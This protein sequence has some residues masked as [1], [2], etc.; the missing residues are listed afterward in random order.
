MRDAFR[1]DKTNTTT[2]D[3]MVI[4]GVKAFLDGF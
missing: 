4:V 3:T 2:C 1:A